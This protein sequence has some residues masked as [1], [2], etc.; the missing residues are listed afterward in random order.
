MGILL[1]GKVQLEVKFLQYTHT[2]THTHTHTRTHT[3]ARTHT[4]TCT[5]A[6]MHTHTHTHT[7]RASISLYRQQAVGCDSRWHL[8]MN[9]VRAPT[10]THV[11]YSYPNCIKYCQDAYTTG[12][13]NDKQ[14]LVGM[15]FKFMQS[16]YHCRP[17]SHA[18]CMGIAQ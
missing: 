15:E 17:Q 7:Y 14:V 11:A 1:A 18:L 9:G 3:Y 6:H 2:H 10:C 12:I 4:H 8:L 13:G 16:R 5:H